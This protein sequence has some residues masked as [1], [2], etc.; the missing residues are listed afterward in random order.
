MEIMRIIMSPL[1]H[2]SMVN[3]RVIFIS[4][5][6]VI[7]FLSTTAWLLPTHLIGPQIFP[8]SR[9]MSRHLGALGEDPRWGA[10]SC[11]WEAAP[12]V[13][14]AG[15][16][17][18][19]AR[20]RTG[21]L[22]TTEK[23]DKNDTQV[24]LREPPCAAQVRLAGC[25]ARPGAELADISPPPALPQHFSPAALL[26]R[27]TPSSD[28]L[29][30]VWSMCS[31]L[32]SGGRV[33]DGKA[34]GMRELWSA[35]LTLSVECTPLLARRLTVWESRWLAGFLPGCWL[36]CWLALQPACGGSGL[37]TLNWSAVCVV[38]RWLQERKPK[39]FL[40]S[41]FFF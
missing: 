4:N 15:L 17:R 34:G 18:D 29:S 23:P 10:F 11:W 36:V 30:A 27:P 8:R 14:L 24:P 1:L 20:V 3:R 12:S 25:S 37:R 32:Q 28:T 21:Q 2:L 22:E 38:M 41:F 31:E 9:S 16:S 35:L 40:F 13:P 5:I 6:M 33:G 7:F 19:S 39:F 26:C